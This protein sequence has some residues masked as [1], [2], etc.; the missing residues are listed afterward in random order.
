MTNYPPPNTFAHNVR[1]FTSTKT[2]LVTWLNKPIK[3]LGLSLA[4]IYRAFLSL[5]R[6]THK[7]Q[8]SRIVGDL[9]VSIP[10][11]TH[12]LSGNLC[13]KFVQ[14]LIGMT[15]VLGIQVPSMG[16]SA[17]DDQYVVYKEAKC[18]GE[19]TVYNSLSEL[20]NGIELHHWKSYRFQQV[21]TDGSQT[22]DEC[23]ELTETVIA[24]LRTLKDAEDQMEEIV[25]IG[26]RIE[27]HPGLFSAATTLQK[28]ENK[29]PRNSLKYFKEI[30]A[31][32]E[33][34][35]EEF[36]ENLL[37][38]LIAEIPAL[39]V[40]KGEVEI[41]FGFPENLTALGEYKSHAIKLNLPGITN[42][43][44]INHVDLYTLTQNVL[45]HEMEHYRER[46]NEDLHFYDDGEH[47]WE[48]LEFTEERFVQEKTFKT[49]R[50][51][52]RNPPPLSYHGRVK[53][54]S[55]LHKYIKKQ[56]NILKDTGVDVSEMSDREIE[57]KYSKELKDL[58]K[59]DG[60][61]LKR[62]P[63]NSSDDDDNGNNGTKYDDDDHALEPCEEFETDDE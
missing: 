18:S 25:V 5:P 45:L 60:I 49:W 51:T 10:I 12:G 22:T 17:T 15:V 32:L 56:K 37:D 57:A 55:V 26:K 33:K 47:K 3:S 52:V 11:R 46:L 13:S 6:Q 44:A 1:S 31:E 7:T 53:F 43:A 61:D 9:W 2:P 27:V 35:M 63:S 14:I 48:D 20:L 23:T 28:L 36:K 41:M 54:N 62:T 59:K 16:G 50:S 42:A 21:N 34:A 40:V 4:R 24:D 19:N 30:L 38:C 39:N 8:L 58:M 29:L